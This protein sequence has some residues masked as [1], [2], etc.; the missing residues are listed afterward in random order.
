[1]AHP[2]ARRFTSGVA[3]RLF[4]ARLAATEMW[5]RL[6]KPLVILIPSAA[7]VLAILYVIYRLVD[8]LPPRHLAI[9]ASMAGS[10]YDDFARQYARILARDGVELE[11]RSSAGAVENLDLL[12]DAASG[13]QAA[14]TTFGVTQPRDAD[15]LYSLGGIFDAAIFIFYRS[16]EPITQ[17]A[18]FRGKRLSIGQPGTAL[19]LLILEV[20]KATDALDAS[21]HLS[22]LDH[23]EAIDALIAGEIDAAI[24]PSHLDG[25]LLQRA[26]AAPGIRLMNVAQAEAIAKTVP[27]LKHVVLWRGLISLT[28]DIPNSDTD[29]LAIR[30]RLLVRKD[31]HPALQ[32]LLLEAM[33]EVHS[34]PGPFNRLREFPAEQPNDLP[35]S[36]AAEAFYRS[37][38]TFWQRYTSFW[39]TSLLNRIVFFVIPIV[40]MLIPLIGFAPRSYRWLHV[41]HI[42]Q[43]HRALGNLERELAQSADRSRFAEYQRRIAEIESAV[44]SL[45]VA[46]PF[47]ADLHRLRMHLRTVQEDVSRMGAAN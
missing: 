47:E 34:A 39:L 45:K 31:L 18:Q 38:P 26:L 21:I 27:G 43:L 46:R 15:I 28:R 44:R 3:D 23:P 11:V 25:I 14:L 9:A 10:G 6:R 5:R 29:L 24:F 40:V 4:A 12:R 16:A 30:N 35:L 42:D 32:Y 13:V 36:P 37:G 2:P 22:D 19:R 33:R 20:L 41:R 8:P 17:F 7:I 1:M